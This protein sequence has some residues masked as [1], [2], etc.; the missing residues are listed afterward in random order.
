MSYH[1][2][3]WGG[4]GDRGGGLTFS[5]PQG[6]LLKVVLED[7]LRLKKLF[8]QRMVQ[9][10]SSCHSSISEVAGRAGSCVPCPSPGGALS[11][12]SPLWFF[13][14]S[15]PS[16]SLGL[17]SQDRRAVGGVQEVTVGSAFWVLQ[18]AFQG[19]GRHKE[20]FPRFE[21]PQKDTCKG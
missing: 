8:A 3:A 12:S 18:W 16:P 14:C 5:L 13:C 15:H 7:Y 11:L 21:E 6:S 9:K 10:A 19:W 1:S 17:S 2:E 20:V 4:W